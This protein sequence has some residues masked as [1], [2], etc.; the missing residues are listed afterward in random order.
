MKGSSQGNSHGSYGRIGVED[1]SN[2]PFSR[3]AGST[4]T[5]IEGNLWLFGGMTW[6]PAPHFWYFNDLWKYNPVTNNWIWMKGSNLTNVG[7]TYGVAGIPASANNPGGREHAATWTDEDGN[8]WI[9]GGFGFDRVGIYGALNDLWKYELSSNN[10]IW[11]NGSEF[12][13]HQGFYGTQGV[14]AISNQPPARS[15][16][17]AWADSNGNLWLFG[18][19]DHNFLPLNDMWRYDIRNNEWTWMKGS[20]VPGV[21]TPVYGVQGIS[22]PLNTPAGKTG[23]NAWTG[24]DGQLYL[25]G[26]TLNHLDWYNDL[27]RYTPSNNEWTWIHGSSTIN[28]VP[29]QGTQGSP[30]A[31]NQPGARMYGCSFNDKSGNLWLFGGYGLPVIP[32]NAGPLNDLWK[33]SPV[34]NQWT[35]MK[36]GESHSTG[37]YGVAAVPAITNKPGSRSYAMSWSGHSGDFWLFGGYGYDG[38]GLYADLNDL[39]T[40]NS[41]VLLPAKLISF[42]GKL[43]QH[44]A[45][46]QWKAVELST[47]S[48]FIIERSFDGIQFEP[49]GNVQ[50]SMQKELYE[51]SDPLAA[52]ND[53]KIFYR[54]KIMDLDN[55]HTYSKVVVLRINYSLLTIYPNPATT[56]ISFALSKEELRQA[57][58]DILDQAGRTIINRGAVSVTAGDKASLDVSKLLPGTY[59][60]RISSI[61]G[62]RS[63]IFVKI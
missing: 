26:G 37:V 11:I 47:T 51:F 60:L 14:P 46:L 1:P 28:Q 22:S 13:N 23:S 18:G 17:A 52:M 58:Y 56:L 48:V 54:L 40:I 19:Y 27:W 39:W 25:F 36:G 59:L 43:Q 32:G 53:Q 9:F 35:W 30:G 15:T 62:T 6:Q 3:W 20:N 34:T 12:T 16:S 41:L 5:D 44:E 61:N 33:Y 29:V 45:L 2:E 8:F 31:A 10:W 50:A 21:I 42:T 55:S 57:N 4:F 63:A 49:V 38:T 24:T 7:G